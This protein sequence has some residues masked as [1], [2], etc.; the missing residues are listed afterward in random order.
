MKPGAPTTALDIAAAVRSGATTAG[1]VVARALQAA[2]SSQDRLNAFTLIDTDGATARA[3]TI[4]AALAA[5]E[6]PGP[7]AGVPFAVKDLIDQEGLRTTCGGSFPV[8]PAF[9]TAPCVARLEEAGA[10]AIGRTGL[11]EFAFGFSS[12]NHWFGP[13]RNPWDKD[14]SPGGSSGG[15]GAAVGAGVVPIALGTDTGGSVRVPAALCGV[16][17]LKVTHGRGSLHGVYPLAGSLDTVG[18][19]ARTVADVSAAYQAIAEYDPRDSWSVPHQVASAGPQADPGSL[20]VG[21]PRPLVD[22]KT[23]DVIAEGFAQALDQLRA[24]GTTITHVDIPSLAPPGMINEGVYY[25][26]ATVHRERLLENPDGYGPEVRERLMATLQYTKE[27]FIEA[28]AW[29]TGLRHAVER[30]LLNCDVLVTPTVA[31]RRKQIGVPEI[32]IGDDVHW[33]AVP[34][35]R[36][37]SVVNHAGLP[38]LALPLVGD[39]RPPASLQL[40]GGPWSEHRLLEIGLGLEAAGIV[41]TPPLPDWVS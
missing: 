41:G 4:D 37:T 40:I 14:L 8:L 30:A 18:P 6:D 20:T 2:A 38:A 24:A 39:A 25:E 34:L 12:E 21:V 17:G 33:Y 23:D 10:I 1:E 22:G 35:S 15:S 16:V 28:R 3:E 31:A 13:V 11:H 27:G 9:D 29:R 26:A 36:Y 19:L 5:G 32:T 7:L